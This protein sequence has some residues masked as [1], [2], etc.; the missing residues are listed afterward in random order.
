MTVHPIVNIDDM[1]LS[2]RS[3]GDDFKTAT[4]AKVGRMQPADDYDGED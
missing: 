3:H 4:Y 1:P 2:D